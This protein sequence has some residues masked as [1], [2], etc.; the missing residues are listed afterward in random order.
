MGRTV[1]R[2]PGRGL[3]R[4]VEA[5]APDLGLPGAQRIEQLVAAGIGEQMGQLRHAG[6]V[7]GDRRIDGQ[8]GGIDDVGQARRVG[9]LRIEGLHHAKARRIIDP[10]ARLAAQR[11]QQ[12]RE[13]LALLGRVAG[14]HGHAVVSARSQ[15][16][17]G[18]GGQQQAVGNR[19]RARQALGH[20]GLQQHARIL[21]AQV[22]RD[23]RRCPAGSHR[24]RSRH[25]GSQPIGHH[26]MGQQQRGLGG[27]G[28]SRLERGQHAGRQ[29]GRQRQ[30]AADGHQPVEQAARRLGRQQRQHIGGPRRLAHERD[31]ARIAAKARDIALHK[32]QRL[33]VV[34]QR[35]VAR[36][37]R[38]GLHLRHVHVA[39]DVQ[40]VVGRHHH[41]IGGACQGRAV[42]QRIGRIARDGA[43]AVDEHQHRQLLGTAGRAPDVER[44]A[45]LAAHGLAQGGGD[46]VVEAVVGA[47]AVHAPDL[48]AGIAEL[49]RLAHALPGL[50]L[51]RR[52][53]AQR[54]HGRL[55]KG[56]ALPVIG[57]RGG[58]VVHA[59]QGAVG[60][61][62]Q[63]GTAA[64]RAAAGREPQ[65]H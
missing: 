56:H 8:V 6:V 62:A 51:G 63:F 49:A 27:V 52:L 16:G 28:R 1:D 54:A 23:L 48:Q 4:P 65:S 61:L 41:G 10:E 44:Q 43:A 42:I 24:G 15:R 20:Q 50:G 22:G 53:P 17:H 13:Q 34:Q 32:A 39:Q 12:G 26:Q 58:A 46:G 3:A 59:A 18:V 5:V 64:A 29:V 47:R 30:P 33:Q 14:H 7:A 25:I 9:R 40:P 19:S 36:G 37:R 2:V 57:A 35:E 45:V 38:A 11:R 60:R 55:G 31:I 21:A